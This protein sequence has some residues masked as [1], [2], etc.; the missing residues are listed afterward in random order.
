MALFAKEMSVSQ[1]THVRNSVVKM[2][3]G[4]N[5]VFHVALSASKILPF[6][7]ESVNRDAFAKRDF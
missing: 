7:S 4:S 2:K 3:N 5:A 6:A 1:K